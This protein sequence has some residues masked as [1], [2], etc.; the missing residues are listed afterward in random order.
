MGWYFNTKQS[1][2]AEL[3]LSSI[4]FA[5]ESKQVVLG[6]SFSTKMTTPV[7]GLGVGYSF[8]L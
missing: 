3:N 6:D 1:L 2:F 5:A 7:I 8:N 4:N